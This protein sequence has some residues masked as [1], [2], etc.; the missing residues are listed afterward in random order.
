[1]SPSGKARSSSG[2]GDAASLASRHLETGS[3]AASLP[4]RLSVAQGGLGLELSAGVA[5]GAMHVDELEVELPGLNYPIDLSRGVKHFRNRRSVLRHASLRV[6]SAALAKLWAESLAEMWGS[7]VRVRLRPFYEEAQLASDARAEVRENDGVAGI[8]SLAVTIH[9]RDEVLAFDLVVLSGTS[10]RIAID[11]P[12]A[13]GRNEPP[14]LLAIQAVDAGLRAAAGGATPEGGLSVSRRGRAVLLGGLAETVALSVLPALGCRLPRVDE[15]VISAVKYDAGEIRL[16]IGKKGE[17]LSAGRRALWV[18]ATSDF[19]RVPD[20]T[21]S[22]GD[23]GGAR[24]AYLELLERAPGHLEALQTLAELDL[25]VGSRGESALSFLQELEGTLGGRLAPLSLARHRLALARAL[26]VTGRRGLVVETLCAALSHENDAVLQALLGLELARREQTDSAKRQRLDV[27]LSRAPFLRQPRWARFELA[28]RT[29]DLRVAASDAEHLEASENTA[30]DRARTCRRVGEHFRAA[31]RLGDAYRW[32]QRA[33]CLSPDDP[34]VMFGLARC[35]MDRAEPLR[36]CELLQ[37][38]VG[39]MLQD[40]PA[41]NESET[42]GGAEDGE[43]GGRS[44]TVRETLSEAR[45]LLGQLLVNEGIDVHSALLHL[46]A[47][48]TRSSVGVEA[49][50]MEAEILHEQG[51]FPQRDRA[52]ARLFE[53]SEMGWID[54][55]KHAGKLDRL[56]GEWGDSMDS[57]VL[58]FAR[59]V[60]GTS[61]EGHSSEREYP[62]SSDAPTL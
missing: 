47:V 58:E 43:F 18:A 24:Q 60:L 2:A 35:L 22:V 5:F 44:E 34:A 59:R 16:V 36:A 12:R 27:A 23:L 39:Q 49:R 54:L 9:R 15:Q 11:S 56:L 37:S 3:K 17:P 25:A 10:P 33:L 42:P 52:L 6:D 31:G 8:P 20:E 57:S 4:L 7:G 61:I 50:L 62:K 53:A 41:R 46:A 28:V 48:E 21:L 14:L 38:S 30:L 32:L 26:E 29:G 55:R 51:R 13:L 40:E 1:M 45:F 19:L